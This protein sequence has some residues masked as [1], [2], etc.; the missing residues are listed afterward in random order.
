MN[1]HE[2]H[3]PPGTPVRIRRVIDY[4]DQAVESEVAGV[5]ERWEQLP[6]GSWWAHGKQHKLWLTRLTLRKA[7][8]ELT[9]LIIDDATSI[10]K[11]EA[12]AK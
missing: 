8:G 6:T 4:R 2:E 7:D 9:Q 12:A 1:M 3:F 5:V 10:A 11:L